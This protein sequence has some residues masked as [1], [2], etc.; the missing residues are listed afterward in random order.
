MSFAIYAEQS[1]T[2]LAIL[3]FTDDCHLMSS[4]LQ[5]SEDG[6]FGDAAALRLELQLLDSELAEAERV[7]RQRV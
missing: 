5:V 3:T 7:N 4:A 6:T 2:N 1:L